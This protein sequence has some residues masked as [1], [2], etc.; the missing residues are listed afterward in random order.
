MFR[1]FRPC[2]AETGRAAGR[3][4]LRRNRRR[5]RRV[6]VRRNP[7]RLVRACSRRAGQGLLALYNLAFIAPL[8]AVFMLA[9][10]GADAARM[11]RW[12]KRNVFPSKLAL[13]VV[14][15]LLDVLVALNAVSG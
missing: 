4:R 13:G 11:S 9:A 5:G 2:R 12:S 8:V 1:G 14:F 6:E 7:Q 3:R 15:V 10:W